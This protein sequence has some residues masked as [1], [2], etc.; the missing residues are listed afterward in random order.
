MTHPNQKN[1]RKIRAKSHLKNKRRALLHPKLKRKSKKLA[2]LLYKSRKAN[3]TPLGTPEFR[4]LRDKW[5]SKLEAK[6][7][8]DLEYIPPNADEATE[9][10]QTGSLSAIA[11]Q[12]KPETLHYYRRI[13]CYLA[14]RKAHIKSKK[15]AAILE[16]YSKGIPF[17]DMT[18]QL[19]SR[20]RKGISITSIHYVIK[21]WLPIIITWNRINA[22]GLDFEPDLEF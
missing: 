18:R 19:K 15:D 12:Y 22:R 6:G 10:I 21:H 3:R 5:Y 4:A 20:F 8:E 14:H 17:R 16:L 11:K 2:K 7:Y 13:S 1:P 9:Y